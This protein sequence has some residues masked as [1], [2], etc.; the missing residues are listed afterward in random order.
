MTRRYE[1]LVHIRPIPRPVVSSSPYVMRTLLPR[2]YRK[3]KLLY[4]PPVIE[5]TKPQPRG[6]HLFVQVQVWKELV[7]VRRERTKPLRWHIL[8]NAHFEY[9]QIVREQGGL[10][11]SAEHLLG[12][13]IDT[14][15]GLAK[16]DGRKHESLEEWMALRKARED[17]WRREAVTIIGVELRVCYGANAEFE[18]P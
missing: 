8:Y 18:F 3:Q 4:V 15:V 14:R 10:E 7:D 1:T 11:H 12:G 16:V 9:L 6:A 13:Y 5:V 2:P 17:L